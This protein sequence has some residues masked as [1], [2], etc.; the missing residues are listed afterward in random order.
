LQGFPDNWD[1]QGT[2]ASKFRQVGN[3]VQGHI[4]LAIGRM[5]IDAAVRRRKAKPESIEWPENFHRRV[6]Y[7]E[8]EGTVNGEHRAAARGSRAA[9]Q[10]T[11]G[12]PSSSNG[13]H[14]PG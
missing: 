1:F 7:T 13:L 12:A 5:L 8:M 4:A 9:S 3:A 11:E 6:R 14:E 2:I 10:A